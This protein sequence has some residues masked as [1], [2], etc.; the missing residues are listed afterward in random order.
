MFKVKYNTYK[1]IKQYKARLVIQG[2]FQVYGIDYTK[3]FS[4]IVWKKASRIFVM[5]IRFFGIFLIK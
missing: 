5:L 2:F 4:L 1:S 3:T